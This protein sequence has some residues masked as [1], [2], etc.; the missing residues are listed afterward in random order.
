MLKRILFMGL[1]AGCLSM[2]VAIAQTKAPAPAPAAPAKQE[3]DPPPAMA[4]PKDYKYD[5]KGRRD[6]FINPVPKPVKA[7]PEAELPRPPGLK[8]VLL[9]E[10]ALKGVIASREPDMNRVVIG[11]PS[12]KTYFAKKGENLFDAVIKDI[13]PGAVVF[14]VR[15]RGLDGKTSTREVVRKVQVP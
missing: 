4:V 8:G 2:A 11:T 6:P 12:G 14:E 9:S 1:M 10:A 5:V 13:Q 3:L 15:S 7:V